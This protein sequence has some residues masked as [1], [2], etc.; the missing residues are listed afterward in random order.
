VKGITA[1]FSRYFKYYLE[2]YLLFKQE[3]DSVEPVENDGLKSGYQLIIV[4][5]DSKK[6]TKSSLVKLWDKAYYSKMNIENSQKDVSRQLTDGDVCCAIVFDEKIVGMSWFGFK[7]ASKRMDFANYLT[8]EKR[9]LLI[10]HS[11]VLP[12]CRGWGAQRYILSYG[13]EFIKKNHEITNMFVFV[14]VRN[15]ASINNRL[16]NFAEYRIVYHVNVNMPFIN[17]NIYPKKYS[18]GWRSCEKN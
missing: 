9:F 1:F 8:E 4:T 11:F 17:F 12:S 7:N 13:V 16:K 14:G 5:N 18:N 2:G 6:E 15:F 10:H 3:I